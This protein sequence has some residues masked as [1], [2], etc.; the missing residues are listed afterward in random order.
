MHEIGSGSAVSNL[1]MSGAAM[2][3]DA[4]G[5]LRGARRVVSPHADERPPGAGVSLIVIH[6][7]SLPPGEF[8]GPWV[9]AFFSGRL[10][11]AAH[12][13]FSEIASLRVAPHF[14]ITRDGA[15]LQFVSTERRAWHAGHSRWEGR[16]E[17][18]DFSIGIE[19]E[20]TDDTPYT[21]A[22]YDRLA[23]VVAALCEY[24]PGIGERGLAGH[25]DIAPGRKTDPGPA[26]DWER[27]VSDMAHAGYNFHRTP[28]KNPDGDT[29]T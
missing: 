1:T 16:D 20:G 15:L 25:S 12:P 22:Q 18:N 8:G 17:C 11:I 7:V 24:Y 6:G 9:E 28:T 13:Y 2:T 23:G 5:W 27:L 26:F 29:G 21:T 19:M 10:D 14:Y 4:E 3:V